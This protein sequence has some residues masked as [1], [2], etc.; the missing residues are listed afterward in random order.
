MIFVS[1]PQFI[2][3]SF[4]IVLQLAAI[5]RAQQQK[6][7]IRV[8]ILPGKMKRSDLHDDAPPAM[9]SSRAL[10]VPYLPPLT[11]SLPSF[12]SNRSKRDEKP[13]VPK[14]RPA[15]L[16]KTEKVNFIR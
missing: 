14:V 11:T 13:S 6:E 5:G 2:L 16:M 8:P 15:L 9:K 7:P 3:V 12:S 10:N 4:G 1:W